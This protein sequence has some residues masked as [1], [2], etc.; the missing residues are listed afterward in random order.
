MSV[1]KLLVE[2]SASVG[3]F[4]SDMGRAAAI[5]DANAR[6]IDKSISSIKN[7]ILGIGAG[8]GA[9]F[10]FNQATDFIKDTIS[11]A[12]ALDD[13]AD[14]TGSTVENLSRLKN[15]VAIS[16]GSFEELQT[17]VLKVG[18]GIAGIDDES[19]KAA[20][21]LAFLGV[22]SKDPAEAVQELAQK[23]DQYADGPGKIA[24]MMD[25]AGKEGGKYLAVLKDVARDTGTLGTVTTEQ[26]QRAEELEKAW[27]RLG[28][29]ATGLKNLILNDLVPALS[30]LLREFSDGIKIAGGF[31]AALANFGTINPF[32]SVDE[33]LDETRK[34]IADLQ[35]NVGG[36]AKWANIL[37]AS[38]SVLDRLKK[39][40]QF[41]LRQKQLLADLKFGASNADARDLRL[42]AAKPELKYTGGTTKVAKEAAERASDFDKIMERLAKDA[43]AADLALKE[44][45][46]TEEI[47]AA[48]RALASLMADDSWRKM[49]E[50]ER[51]LVRAKIAAIDA[52]Q[53]QT[54][55]AKAEREERERQIR[56]QQDLERRQA[57]AVDSVARSLA[58]YVEGNDALKAEIGLVGQD[59]SARARLVA[60]MEAERAARAAIAAYGEDTAGA[61]NMIAVIEKERD[62]RI[63]LID[64]LAAKVREFNNTEQIRSIFA[65][66]FADQ[67][68]QVVDGTKSLSDAFRDMERQIVSSISRIAAQ[69]LADAIFGNAGSGG[70]FGDLFK[71]IGS[72]IPAFA[73]GTSFAPGGLALVGERGPEIVNLPRGSKVTPNGSSAGSVIS[74]NVNV[75]SG[76]AAAS[77]D[78]IALV[79]GQAVQRAMRRNG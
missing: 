37:G 43:A 39:R 14:S 42:D 19:G 79:T 32:Q 45:F 78:R 10:S 35:D 18:K 73:G 44:A 40:E 8:I 2:L 11:A 24:L 6:K 25:I 15:V 22:A 48:Q 65:D 56:V 21:A 60:T 49:T 27:R 34:K 3:K 75:P 69:N 47:T 53:R 58:Q 41:L 7:T 71:S 16:G 20:K 64:E 67:I 1:G 5:A 46:S 31:W 77:A 54:S 28:V 50:G 12:S 61:L 74:I 70:F 29:E 9:A 68:A 72:A 55:A 63:Q 66:N 76:T 30:R 57:D 13:L 26:A 59:N 38:D 33:N 52:I 62:A 36:Q 4:Q 23:L 51:E 17:L